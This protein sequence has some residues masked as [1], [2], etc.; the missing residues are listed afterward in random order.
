MIYYNLSYLKKKN[1]LYF[2]NSLLAFHISY[3]RDQAW[4]SR[5]KNL[6]QNSDKAFSQI[7]EY[8]NKCISRGKSFIHLLQCINELNLSSIKL[9]KVVN[10]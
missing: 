10:I 1:Y 3:I 4:I 5:D 7:L 9:Q 6:S 2:E 8:S